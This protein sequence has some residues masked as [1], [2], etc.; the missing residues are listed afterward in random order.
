M[1]KQEEKVIQPHVKRVEIVIP[2]AAKVRKEMKIE[3]ASEASRKQ[4]GSHVKRACGHLHLVV[5]GYARVGYRCRC[6]QATMERR[7]SSRE[8]ERRCHPSRGL[9]G[10]LGQYDESCRKEHAIYLSKKF[11]DCENNTFTARENLTYFGIGC[12]PTETVYAGSYRFVDFEMDLI[13]KQS[14]GVL[15]DYIAPQSVENYQPM[16]FEFPDEDISSALVTPKGSHVPFVSRLAFE[17]TDSMG[18]CEACILGIVPRYIYWGNA[19]L[20]G[21]WDGSRVTG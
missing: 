17:C 16:R 21:V 5:S 8:A 15:S 19:F 3:A 2:S 1:S 6:A 11:T 18:K 4:N 14:R 10:V 12:S 7:L 13:R 9:R 20:V